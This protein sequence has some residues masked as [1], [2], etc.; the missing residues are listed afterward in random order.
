MTRHAGLGFALD[1]VLVLVFVLIGRGSHDEGS[2]LI[3][4]LTTLWPFLAALLL[5]WVVTRSWRS[6][7]GSCPPGS[8]SGR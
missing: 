5:G 3:G 8:S 4:L 1:A 2:A 7:T 6:R